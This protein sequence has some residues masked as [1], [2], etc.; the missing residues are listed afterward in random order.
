[1]NN[2]QWIILAITIVILVIIWKRNKSNDAGED[3]APALKYSNANVYKFITPMKHDIFKQLTID[4]SP[5]VL[6]GLVSYSDLF[7]IKKFEE[8][9]IGKSLLSGVGYAIYY[10]F[11]Q[12]Y[13]V[14]IIPNF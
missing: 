12:P 3:E 11:V 4:I 10:Q 14:N 13:L 2:N 7:S 8:S 6:L 1:M 9:P 5:L